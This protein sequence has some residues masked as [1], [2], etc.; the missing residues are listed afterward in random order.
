MGISKPFANHC[1]RSCSGVDS[2]SRDASGSGRRTAHRSDQHAASNAGVRA[3]SAIGNHAT[4]LLSQGVTGT[5][6]AVIL[7]FTGTSMGNVCIGPN[8]QPK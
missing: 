6:R 8:R 1:E 5:R 3:S 7:D 2:R 4:R